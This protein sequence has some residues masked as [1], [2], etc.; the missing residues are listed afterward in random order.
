MTALDAFPDDFNLADH[1]LFD[2][3]AEG[4]GD[5]VAI[6]FGERRY[7]YASVAAHVRA[8]ASYLAGAGVGRAGTPKPASGSAKEAA[9][10]GARPDA[11]VAAA[12]PPKSA[13]GSAVAAPATGPAASTR[14]A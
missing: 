7:T 9:G 11:G 3:L 14:I 6:L 8:L 1:L 4:L 2:R 10:A 5:K 12:S 13:K